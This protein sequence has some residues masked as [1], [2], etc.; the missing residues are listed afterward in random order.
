MRAM[1]LRA[2]LLYF[3]SGRSESVCPVDSES[4]RKRSSIADWGLGILDWGFGGSDLFFIF[5]HP[6]NRDDGFLRKYAPRQRPPLPY[7]YAGRK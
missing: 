6:E 4:M 1:V 5:C 2:C 3:H 7:L